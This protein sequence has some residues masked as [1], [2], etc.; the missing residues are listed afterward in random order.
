MSN[1]TG[2][3]VF[4]CEIVEEGKGHCELMY[5]D[6]S[7]DLETLPEII[8]ML[9]DALDGLTAAIKNGAHYHP[10]PERLN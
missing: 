4:T 9:Q 10:M 1:I 2:K 3:V 5:N 6:G 7:V 8:S